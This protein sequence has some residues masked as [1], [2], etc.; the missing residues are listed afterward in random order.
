MTTPERE[1]WTASEIA[2]SGLPDLPSSRQ[3]ADTLAK[4][5]GWRGHPQFARRRAG[6]GG[7]WEYHWKLFPQRARIALL[8]A[9]APVVSE[10]QGMD[11]GE[12]WAWFDDLPQ[13]VKDE[14]RARLHI[15]QQVEQMEAGLGKHMAVL[16]IAQA[17][18]KG[19]RTVWNW[20]G[21]IEGIDPADR[22]AYLA[23]R[24]RAAKPKRQRA[25]CSQEFLDWLKAD[26]L[27]LGEP[28]FS[29]CYDRVVLAISMSHGC[30]T[31]ESGMF[32]RL[33]NFWG[34]R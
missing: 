13:H 22:L 9:A 6:R 30:C 2:A 25:E 24:H 31:E 34:T 27:R 20:F 10:P 8:K 26:F 5:N 32:V 3:G 1:W 14:A 11:R 19:A 21:M 28:S 18:G 12:V 7:G 4:R 17:N 23:P 16:T 33:W 15:V 29:S